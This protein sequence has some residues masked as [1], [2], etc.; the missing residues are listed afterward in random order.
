VEEWEGE[1]GWDEDE[2]EDEEVEM[3]P[4]SSV[5]RARPCSIG[6]GVEPGF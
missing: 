2:D 3:W 1:E 5:M 6:K 4:R